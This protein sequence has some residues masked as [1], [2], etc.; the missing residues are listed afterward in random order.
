MKLSAFK[1]E[2][3]EELL[4]QNPAEQYPEGSVAIPRRDVLQDS[5]CEHR[6]YFGHLSLWQQLEVGDVSGLARAELEGREPKPG[7]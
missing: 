3:P 6:S 5:E 1:F 2:L 4:A 7:R